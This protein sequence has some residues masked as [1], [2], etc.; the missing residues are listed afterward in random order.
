MARFAID[1]KSLIPWQGFGKDDLRLYGEVCVTGWQNYINHDSTVKELFKFYENRNDRTLWMLGFDAPTCKV[2]DILSGEL[3]WYPNRYPNSGY[4]IVGQNSKPLPQPNPSPA[5][6]QGKVYPLFW[7]IYAKKTIVDKFSII[8][9]FAHD[10]MRPIN[11]TLQYQYT[12]DVLE[13]KG[14]WWWAFRLNVK[15]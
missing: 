3:E 15:Y 5:I 11:N 4:Y 6:E 14:D 1:P 10:H 12:E 7:S 13:R 9:Q 2:L 8:L